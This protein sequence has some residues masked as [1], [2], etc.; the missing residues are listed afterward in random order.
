G[1]FP[2]FWATPERTVPRPPASGR[3]TPSHPHIGTTVLLPDTHR[4]VARVC[5]PE[6]VFLRAFP[7]RWLSECNSVGPI[8]S[9]S[10]LS[11][12]AAPMPQ[13]CLAGWR[14]RRLPSPGLPHWPLPYS[15][16]AS[17]HAVARHLSIGTDRETGV[18]CQ[19]WLCWLFP[20]GRLASGVPV[21]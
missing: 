5:L 17:N 20:A 10:A 16:R 8:W 9:G 12:T 13:C 4:P 3:H 7:C 19:L 14:H 1:I 11:S 2:A 15:G 21:Q 18:A 6:R